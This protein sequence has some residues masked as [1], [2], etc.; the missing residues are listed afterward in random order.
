M[1]KFDTNTQQAK[2]QRAERERERERGGGGGRAGGGVVT[3]EAKKPKRTENMS[4]PR[5]PGGGG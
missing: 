5:S 2:Q 4:G 3:N 1:A